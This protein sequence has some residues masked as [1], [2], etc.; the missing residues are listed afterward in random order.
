ML[1]HVTEFPSFLKGTE[2]FT[3]CM[4]HIFF[5]HSSTDEPLGCF[6]L[7]AI[8]NNAA[9]NMGVQTSLQDAL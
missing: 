2:D 4:G 7:L 1:W 9:V 5:N 8:V 3:V 6:C